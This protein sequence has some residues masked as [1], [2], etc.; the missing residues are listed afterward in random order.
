M[1]TQRV[2]YREGQRLRAADLQAEQAYHAGA[3]RRHHLGGHTWGIVYGLAPAVAGGQL[4][5]QPGLAV[6][7][8]GRELLLAEATAVDP[9]DLS[10]ALVDAGVSGG[11]PA[12]LWLVL[13]AIL[14]AAGRRWRDEAAVSYTHLPRRRP[15]ATRWKW[16]T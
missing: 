7:G 13:A 14:D 9:A 4:V 1:N 16:P 11:G 12:D 10:A 2:H 5:V 15:T 8:Y 6:D 3:R